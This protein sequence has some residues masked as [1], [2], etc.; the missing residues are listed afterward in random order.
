MLRPGPFSL[1]LSEVRA[2][3]RAGIAKGDEASSSLAVLE[4]E[5]TALKPGHGG[6][7]FSPPQV[8]RHLP[9][10]LARS[11]GTPAEGLA[12][13]LTVCLPRL[14]WWDMQGLYGAYPEHATF[15]ANYAFTLVAGGTFKGQSC[16][17]A[18]E[19]MFLG[20]TLQGPNTLYPGHFHKAVEIYLPISGQAEWFRDRDGWRT[21]PP[22]E[23]FH[24][25]ANEN[26]AMRTGG[27]PL[28]ALFAW[29]SDLDS[30]VFLT[31]E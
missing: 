16:P 1:L 24:H 23:F 5:I 30:G 17:F 27:E 28:L 9:P 22:G 26:H 10:A 3:C 20:F 7:Q 13:A 6:D 12:A 4:R 31:A 21:R 8:E 29:I 19:T 15:V 14:G 11:E 25:E 2:L 18:C